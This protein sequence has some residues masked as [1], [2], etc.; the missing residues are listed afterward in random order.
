MFKF[1]DDISIK[2]KILI[3]IFLPLAMALYLSYNNVWEANKTAENMD[4]ISKLSETAV[5]ASKL[6]HELQKER[7]RSSG[8]LNSKGERF[9]SELSAQRLETEKYMKL[10]KESFSEINFSDYSETLKLTADRI[11]AKLALLESIRQSIDGLSISA[12]EVVKRYTEIIHYIISITDVIGGYAS[13][14][15]KLAAMI[16]SYRALMEMK[17][18]NGIMR[19]ALTGVFARN[20]FT[21]Y[22]YAR[23]LEIGAEH[24]IYEE[25][26]LNKANSEII[27]LH[28]KTVKG[29]A[30][31]ETNSMIK[32]ALENHAS[33]NL[34]VDPEKWFHAI[35]AKIDLMKNVEDGIATKI[36]EYSYKLA[37][38]ASNARN[39]MT[40]LILIALTITITLLV[41]ISSRM[42]SRLKQ[43]QILAEQ[44]ASGNFDLGIVN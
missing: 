34:Q 12:D 39:Y 9:S 43:A 21:P 15:P 41:A 38:D 33:L 4:G 5:S 8:F 22:L 23:V 32:Y 1:I 35:S 19:A 25:I 14:E 26:F 18:R 16:D 36:V 13:E 17:E 2:W 44:I 6:V 11:N 24:N 27:S 10:Y 29:S 30:V 31:D 20:A 37:D 40:I 42:A 28:N 7:G 3:I